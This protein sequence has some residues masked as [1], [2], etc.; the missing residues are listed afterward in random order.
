MLRFT[1]DSR[2]YIVT[3]YAH[4][5]N[6]NELLWNYE[7]IFYENLLSLKIRPFY[8]NFILQKFGAIRYLHMY[9]YI[10]NIQIIK[11]YVAK[12]AT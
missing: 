9:R 10:K 3:W 8:K 7:F 1:S 4:N 5:I 11:I 6:F 2:Y 12:I